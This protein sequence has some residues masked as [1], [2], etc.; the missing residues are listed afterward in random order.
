[1]CLGLSDLTHFSGLYSLICKVGIILRTMC[2]QCDKEM[3]S[4][5][6]P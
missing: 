3:K 5:Y 2:D 4:Y 6:S 1:M